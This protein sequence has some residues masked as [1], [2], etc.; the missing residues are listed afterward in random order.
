MD[1]IEA[2]PDIINFFKSLNYVIEKYRENDYN[3][4]KACLQIYRNKEAL[5]ATLE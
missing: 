3:K 2:I 4:Y 5:S 1:I